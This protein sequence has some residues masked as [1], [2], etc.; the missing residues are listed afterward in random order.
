MSPPLGSFNSPLRSLFCTG[1]PSVHSA[2]VP[3]NL[4]AG[5]CSHLPVP[6]FWDS[7]R[8][9]RVLRRCLQRLR[10][11]PPRR[12][13]QALIHG[14]ISYRALCLVE[15][16]LQCTNK[17][18]STSVKRYASFAKVCGDT[19]LSPSILQMFCPSIPLVTRNGA[20]DS[21]RSPGSGQIPMQLI[22]VM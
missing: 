19:V 14:A 7:L 3:N 20:S 10:R 21:K 5:Y 12:Q 8:P 9:A 17:A 11:R 4:K 6:P 18:Q 16:A 1:T 13:A 22:A 2:S 15:A